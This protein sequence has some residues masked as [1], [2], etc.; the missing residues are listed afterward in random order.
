MSGL[1]APPPVKGAGP[2]PNVLLPGGSEDDGGGDNAGVGESDGEDDGEGVQAGVG[3][4]AGP[5]CGD[6]K[7]GPGAV[8]I[9]PPGGGP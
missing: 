2:S 4:E 8:M 9:A 7:L 6:G 3:P 5:S 1:R